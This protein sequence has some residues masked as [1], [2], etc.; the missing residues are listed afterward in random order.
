MK[1]LLFVLFTIVCISCQQEKKEPKLVKLSGP[2]FGTSFNIQYASEDNI[3]YA[4]QIDSL[5]NVINQSLSTYIS[6]SDISRLNRNENVEID[7]HFKHV[8]RS[9]KEIYEATEG[10]SDPT[11]GNVVNAWSF[12]AENNEFLTDSTTIDSLMHFVGL[13]KINDFKLD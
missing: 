3:N 5:F 2:V 9:S 8:L 12:G 10:V 1:K 7:D 4:K 13:N 6:D 11:I